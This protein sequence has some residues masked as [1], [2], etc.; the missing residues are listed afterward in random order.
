[1]SGFSETPEMLA[2]W[3]FRRRAD[4]MSHTAYLTESF[5]Q[6]LSL[7]QQIVELQVT[8]CNRSGV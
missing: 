1:M 4:R 2:I 7:G 3:G 6:S 5:S 8:A